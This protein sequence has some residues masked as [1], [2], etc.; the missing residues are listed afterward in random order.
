VR[1]VEAACANVTVVLIAPAGWATGAYSR[2]GCALPPLPGIEFGAY[3]PEEAVRVLAATGAPTARAGGGG[4]DTDES[5]LAA[6][7]AML[8]SSVLPAFGRDCTDLDFLAGVAA[9]L[10]PLYWLAQGTMFWALFVV[11]HDW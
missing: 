7:A 11:G 8:R 9:W 4:D 1:A 6:Y 3:T 10:W 5:L 2:D